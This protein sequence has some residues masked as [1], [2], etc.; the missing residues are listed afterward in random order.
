MSDNLVDI[1]KNL[2]NNIDLAVEVQSIVGNKVFI[3]GSTLQITIG[4]TVEDS[5]GNQYT[6]T[7]MVV[8][9]WIELT[10]I[11]PA[12]AFDDTV[13]FGPPI[14]YLHG[15]PMSVN[16]E[17]LVVSS[18]TIDKTP[19]CWVLEPYTY[20][21]PGADSSLS[22]VYE[23]V[24]FFMDWAK[25]TEWTNNEHNNRV[26]KP[27]ENLANAFK[28]TINL[29]FTFKRLEDFVT[30]PRSRF[31]VEVT[32]KGSEGKILDEDLSGVEVRF[33]LEAYDVKECC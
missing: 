27:M 24:L 15:T 9:E 20:R 16:N 2:I 14:T 17:Y 26:I 33:T 29:D 30:K 31:G 12:P 11:S 1:I 25:E 18:D 28:N 13:L 3:C 10:P 8:N 7:D 4:K 19:F 6:V 5:N 32:N 22:G 23:I 21:Q